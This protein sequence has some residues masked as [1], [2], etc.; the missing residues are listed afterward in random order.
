MSNE[1]STTRTG[2]EAQARHPEFFELLPTLRLRMTVP[3]PTKT[4]GTCDPAEFKLRKVEAGEVVSV[5]VVEDEATGEPTYCAV[6][7]DGQK[8]LVP[9]AEK[10]R[11]AALA[12]QA[13]AN[14]TSRADDTAAGPRHARNAVTLVPEKVEA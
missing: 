1:T 6:T 5:R 2:R 14:K 13:D 12:A 9:V 3:H 7:M 11:K 10:A 4:G 8:H